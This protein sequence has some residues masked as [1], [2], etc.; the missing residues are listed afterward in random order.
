MSQ[1]SHA[2]HQGSIL[3]S[4]L[5]STAFNVKIP[6]DGKKKR[7]FSEQLNG[8]SQLVRVTLWNFTAKN[9]H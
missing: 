7:K 2:W 1:F 6:F 3:S 9:M 4:A 8:L 5:F